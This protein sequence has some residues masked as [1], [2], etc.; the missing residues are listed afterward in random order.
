MTEVKIPYVGLFSEREDLQDAI[1]Y[2]DMMVKAMPS[3]DRLPVMTVFH[4]FMNTL[5]KHYIVTERVKNVLIYRA[6]FL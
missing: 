6:D 5:S 1:D 4:V 3:G 2:M